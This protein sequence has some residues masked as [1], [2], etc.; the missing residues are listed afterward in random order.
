MVVPEVNTRS[1]GGIPYKWVVAI[2]VIFG[3]FMS[4]LDS[5]IVNIAISRLQT[6]FGADLNSVQWV[7]T[8]YTLAQGV[9]TPLTAYLADRFGTKRIY[10]LAL[11]AFTLGSALCGLAWSLP[12]LIF[13]RVLQGMGGA[14]L[15]PLSITLLYKEFPPQE[16]GTAMGFL[17]IPI[18][19]APAFGPTLGGYIVT[20]AN[21]PLIFYINVPIGIVGVI[22]ASLFLHEFRSEQRSNFDLAGFLLSASG[23]AILL[24]GL[25]S[26]STDG[27]GSGTVIGCIAVGA[28][29]LAL[30]VL[31]ELNIARSG[32]QPLLN[33]NVF[34]NGLFVSSNIASVLVT[35]ALYG[36]LFMMPLYLQNLRGLSAYQ[37]GLVLLPQAFASMIAVLVGGR[38]VDK[39]G[40]RIVVIPGLIMMAY[41]SWALSQVT[42]S[43]P[44]LS[45]QGLL[46]LRGFSIGLCMQPLMVSAL[47]E[48]K[49][50][51]IAQAS[52]VSTALRFVASSLTVA[53]IATILQS[54]T[55][56]HT[57][58]LAVQATPG[59]PLGQLIY[60]LQASFMAKGMDMGHA[61]QMAAQ[62]VY[63]MLELRG[64]LMAVQDVFVLSAV[65]S[66]VAV[67]A[68]LFVYTKRTS[69][70][71]TEEQSMSEEERMETETAREEALLAV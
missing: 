19:L 41:A 2:V 53:I 12:V 25:S 31:V 24:Y 64:Y 44:I 47:A 36:G 32:R 61:F 37:A 50:R 42:L 58:H 56:I 68:T 54:Q 62:S 70:S 28:V 29:L 33:M 21:W 38:L 34:T 49:P 26:A 18:L 6:A 8:G 52:S 20:F 5:T 43:I 27:W 67:I 46:A 57:D 35:F 39:L 30:F 69:D 55:K 15:M 17:G 48:I 11:A 16:R 9:V 3:L 10:I 45:L 14:L 65:L 23:L 7:I 60:G 51:M 40:V 71:Q 63:G 66:V 13:F 22:M 4:V 1:L 59:S